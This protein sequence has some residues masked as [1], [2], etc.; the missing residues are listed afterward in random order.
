MKT[1]WKTEGM[2]YEIDKKYSQN[3]GRK[4]ERDRRVIWTE[5]RLT[6]KMLQWENFK[7]LQTTMRLKLR[8]SKRIMTTSCMT[9]KKL[10]VFHGILRN[11]VLE[12]LKIL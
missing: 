12:L 6:P 10:F 5:I 7:S 3:E 8:L 4:H 2:E 9:K 1:I 11:S